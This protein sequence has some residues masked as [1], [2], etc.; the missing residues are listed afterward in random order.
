MLVLAKK[1]LL[2]D[3]K[4]EMV[5]QVQ[6]LLLFLRVLE[7]LFP[8]KTNVWMAKFLLFELIPKV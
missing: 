4:M 8:L 3:S 5:V 7:I 6:L 1:K 2:M